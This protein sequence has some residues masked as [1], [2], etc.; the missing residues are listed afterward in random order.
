MHSR[1]SPHTCHSSDPEN[2]RNALSTL[3]PRQ[4]RNSVCVCGGVVSKGHFFSR[5]VGVGQESQCSQTGSHKGDDPGPLLT[6]V[7]LTLWWP[8][9]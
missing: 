6:C 3:T 9:C 1:T 7:S 2:S 4:H 5:Q 8:L